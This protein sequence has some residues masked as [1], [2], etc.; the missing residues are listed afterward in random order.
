MF[1]FSIY[2]KNLFY[3]EIYSFLFLIEEFEDFYIFLFDLYE[4]EDDSDIET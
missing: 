3:S 1:C 2:Y 4:H